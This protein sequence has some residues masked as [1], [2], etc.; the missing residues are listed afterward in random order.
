MDERHRIDAWLKLVCLFKKRGDAADAC[1]GGHVKLNGVRAKPATA[2]QEGDVIE[3]LGGDD[4]YHRVVV[5]ALP[6]APVAKAVARTMYEDETPKQDPDPL[7]MMLRE[8][9]A[10]RPTKRDRRDMEKLKRS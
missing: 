7:R 2:V 4:R 3:Y 10:G 6:A 5:V 1:R 9:G 8:R